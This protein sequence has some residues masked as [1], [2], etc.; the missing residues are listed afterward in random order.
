MFKSGFCLCLKKERV[1]RSIKH[2]KVFVLE[3]VII[4]HQESMTKEKDHLQHF[5]HLQK[6]KKTMMQ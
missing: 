5:A 4:F 6:I 1:R 3:T 2:W